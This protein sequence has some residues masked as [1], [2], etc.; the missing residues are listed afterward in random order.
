MNP[1]DHTKNN[2][3]EAL[4]LD[5][6]EFLGIQDYLSTL[7]SWKDLKK[8][9]LNEVKKKLLPEHY[10]VIAGVVSKAV[11]YF[12]LRMLDDESSNELKEIYSL[13]SFTI[14][15]RY[16][17]DNP[18]SLCSQIAEGCEDEV[19][20]F[21]SSLTVIMS[22]LVDT[23]GIERM[24][25]YDKFSELAELAEKEIIDNKNDCLLLSTL[26]FLNSGIEKQTLH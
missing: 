10:R 3:S 23:I 4:G 25:Q 18:V 14:G 1:Y 2:M 9:D 5:K 17:T 15:S 19:S 7:V 13:I 26:W 20:S 21:I 11:T 24:I 12:L 16:K 22:I 6:D 8:L